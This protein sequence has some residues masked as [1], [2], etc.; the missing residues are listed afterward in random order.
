MTYLQKELEKVKRD[1][2]SLGAIVEDRFQKS[3]Q[4]VRANDTKLA[5]SVIEKDIEIDTREI[6]IEEECL[7]LLALYQPVA[8]DLR[9]IIV[10]IKIN[11][12]LE[13]IGDLSANISQRLLA[14]SK[15]LP[16]T[17]DYDYSFMAEQTGLM[18]KM[19][20]DSLVTMDIE[21]AY[22]ALLMDEEINLMR[23]EAFGEMKK[24]IKDDPDDVSNIINMYLISRHI[25]RIGDHITNIAEEVIHL[26]EGEIIR[27]KNKE[28]IKASK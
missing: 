20:L 11:N 28:Y 22:E 13:R 26:V 3:A 1:I 7:K 23:D 9:S 18:F 12:D 21:T 8:V 6:E 25:E 10:A 15:N 14:A 24:A 19:S 5:L 2:L 4:A 16:C 27:H 17:Y